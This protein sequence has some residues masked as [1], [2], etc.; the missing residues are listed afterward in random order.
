MKFLIA[1]VFF[2]ISFSYAL[3]AESDSSFIFKQKRFVQE[4]F[5]K[6]Q[7]FDVVA[8]TRRLIAADTDR[9]NQKDYIFFI[10]INYFLGG[11]YQTVVRRMREISGTLDH[12]QAILLSQSYMKL[13]MNPLCLETVRNLAYLSVSP[14]FRYPLLVR[15]AEAYLQCG[16]YQE[17]LDEIK[18][19]E[20]FITE[21]DKLLFMGVEVARFRQLRL[22]SIPLAVA[23]SVFLPGMGQIY[24]GNYIMGIVSFLGVA[25]MAGGGFLFLSRGQKDLLYTFIFFSSVLYL[26]NIYGAYST[27]QTVN[28]DLSRGFQEA[29]RQKC[30]PAYDSAA[31]VRDNHIFH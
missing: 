2:S 8:E 16:L 27:V 17:I 4:L 10:D 18:N 22:K 12:R 5:F 21:R 20:K 9:E 24:A 15:K 11:Q 14:P 19:A 6:K 1:I 3:G 31:E 28:E 30:I 25:A 26:G 23:L 7:Y 29:I 13:G